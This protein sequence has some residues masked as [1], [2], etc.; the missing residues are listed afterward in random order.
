MAERPEDEN[1]TTQSGEQPQTRQARKGV[2]DTDSPV[3]TFGGERVDGAVADTTD[4]E[5][6]GGVKKLFG[7]GKNK[8]KT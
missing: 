4:G 2:N 6:L 8:K 3:H 5:Y 7:I 1:K